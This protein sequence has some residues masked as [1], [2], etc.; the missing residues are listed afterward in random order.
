MKSQTNIF[1]AGTCE[2][3]LPMVELLESILGRVFFPQFQVIV[4]CDDSQVEQV[5]TFTA[6]DKIITVANNGVVEKC[7]AG[8]DIIILVDDA[9]NS[10]LHHQ[11]MSSF[12]V[13]LSHDV[14]VIQPALNS[15]AESELIKTAQVVDEHSKCLLY[16]KVSMNL[17]KPFSVVRM[18][19]VTEFSWVSEL[20]AEVEKQASVD[21]RVWLMCDGAMNGVIGFMNCLL[22]ETAGKYVR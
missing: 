15:Y 8:A 7:V 19:S 13:A 2:L 22:Q 14:L 6:R 18:S 20:I 10:Y 16:R 5:K 11:S 21:G 4:A 3:F 9:F 17:N 1:V 12:L